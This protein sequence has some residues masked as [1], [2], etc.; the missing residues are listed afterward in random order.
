MQLE[1][2]T[3]ESRCLLVSHRAPVYSKLRGQTT[4][5]ST[6]IHLKCGVFF[7]CRRHF[8][9]IV[10]CLRISSLPTL[11]ATQTQLPEKSPLHVIKTAKLSSRQK[12]ASHNIYSI[13][14]CETP[15]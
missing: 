14:L 15:I 9:D 7:F 8:G 3:T 11:S 4:E 5:Y 2:A 12:F 13:R 6:G 1:G 10:K